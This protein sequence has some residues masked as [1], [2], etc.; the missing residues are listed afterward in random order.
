MHNLKCK[1]L[2]G[3]GNYQG[4]SVG[5]V[6][7]SKAKQSISTNVHVYVVQICW[8]INPLLYSLTSIGPPAHTCTYMYTCILN[9]YTYMY[10]YYPNVHHA[11]ACRALRQLYRD[12]DIMYTYTC[13]HGIP[14]YMYMYIH[15]H[16]HV[17][18]LL[19]VRQHCSFKQTPFLFPWTTRTSLREV[20]RIC[21]TLLEFTLLFWGQFWLV[22]FASF[23]K[24]GLAE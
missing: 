3:S 5:N 11:H 13:T 24:R 9:V 19:G 23:E 2:G 4:S 21:F 22:A 6:K 8:H 17:Y 7:A 1:M 20:A 12:L 18:Y 15:V 16:V 10:M 14:V